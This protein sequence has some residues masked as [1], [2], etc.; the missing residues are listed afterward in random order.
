MRE[1]C[2]G[3][4]N[5]KRQVLSIGLGAVLLTNP[6]VLRLPYADESAHDYLDESRNK[7]L[8]AY[9]ICR[10]AN[11]AISVAK[12]SEVSIGI[13]GTGVQVAAGQVLDPVDELVERT[14][15]LLL[16]AL[17]SLVI[18]KL[19]Y[20]FSVWISPALC[21][22]ALLGAGLFGFLHWEHSKSA[23][24]FF[25]MALFMILLIRCVVPVS[26]LL[27][28]RLDAAYFEQQLDQHSIAV[29]PPITLDELRDLDRVKDYCS[30][31]IKNMEVFTDN[32]ISTSAI[33]L[34]KFVVEV[35]LFPLGFFWCFATYGNRFLGWNLSPV[36]RHREIAERFQKNPASEGDPI[37]SPPQP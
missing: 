18:Q 12:E 3:F 35:I 7:A 2:S 25:V 8:A 32:L 9:G 16:T 29:L 15:D 20:E 17:T 19:V 36:L 27:G 14:S 1:R 4:R 33:M 34:T 5:V 26:A 28:E 37:V 21:G 31:L 30:A 11:A 10:I 23:S 24:R 6:Q 13:F 22:V